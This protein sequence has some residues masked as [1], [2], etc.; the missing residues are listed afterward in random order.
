M[1]TTS[2]APPSLLPALTAPGPPLSGGSPNNECA[3]PSTSPTYCTSAPTPTH[4]VSRRDGAGQT[5]KFRTHPLGGAGGPVLSALGRRLAG[6]VAQRADV[7]GGA[8]RNG[9]VL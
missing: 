7:C 5:A 6:R 4:P 2:R 1:R 8:G 9:V 3:R